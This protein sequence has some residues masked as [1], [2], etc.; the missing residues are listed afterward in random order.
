[1]SGEVGGYVIILIL[2][3]GAAAEVAPQ[4]GSHAQFMRFG[5]RAA[6]LN[7]L[8]SA[9]A[10]AEIDRRAHGGGAHV[11]GFLNS[12][13]QNLAELVRE[14]EEFVVI[15]LHDKGNLVGVFTS[16]GTQNSV[17]GG[18]GV[19]AAFNRQLDD[20]FAVEI[21][22]IL[23]EAGAAR[24]LDALI[25]WKNGKIAGAAEAARVEQAMEIVR[26]RRLRSEAA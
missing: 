2:L 19:A 17:G 13:K 18:D 21:I 22:G 9:V 26:T 12:A 5:K 15:D 6:D 11:I 8:A 4:H 24:M 10:G 16:D 23:G 14:G 7:D 20:I 3:E 1:L 25:D